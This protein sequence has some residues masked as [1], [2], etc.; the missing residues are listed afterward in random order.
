MADLPGDIGY[1]TVS[2]KASLGLADSNDAGEQPDRVAATAIVTFTPL[3]GTQDVIVAVA[4]DE[5]VMPQ[6]IKCT[7]D[8]TGRLVPPADGVGAAPDPSAPK[9][10]QL[11]APNQASLN[12]TGWSW[13]ATFAPI[14]PQNWNPFSR[15]FTGAPGDTVSLAQ[16]TATTPSPGVLSAL[17]FE[18]ATTAEPFPAGYRVGVDLL[19]TPDGNLWS[20]EA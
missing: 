12:Y 14:A 8:S 1:L 3:L 10:V 2:G 7:L 19:L 16:L 15:V 17:I 18:V 11:I 6:P 20:T 5:I 4:D 13:R 9:Y